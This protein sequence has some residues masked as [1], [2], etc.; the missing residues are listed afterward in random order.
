MRHTFLRLAAAAVTLLSLAGAPAAH[1]A[2]L[3]DSGTSELTSVDIPVPVSHLPTWVQINASTAPIYAGDTGTTTVATKVPR[4]TFLK[5]LAAGSVRLQ[6]TLY[7]AN[8]QPGPTGWVEPDDVAPSAPATDWLVAARSTTLQHADGSTRQLDQ[9]APLQQTDGPVQ[10]RLEVRVYK[11]DFSGVL[12][13]GWVSASDTGPALPPQTHVPSGDATLGRRAAAAPDAQQTFL[14][15]AEGA[16]VA[17]KSQTGVPA[18]VTVAQAILESDWGR[19]TLAT[20]A[21]NYFGIKAMGGLGNDGVVWL[22]TSEFNADGQEYQT[23]SPFRAYKSLT[24]SLVDHDRL[25]SGLARYAPAMQAASDPRQFA[26]LLSQAGYSTDPSYADK[27]IALMDSYNL[28]GL[29]A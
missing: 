12:D 2:V 5:V 14:K 6:I 24:D 1:A 16:A 28:Y 22:P 7:D 8:A 9:F 18:S 29:D 17:A 21:S 25:L 23:I 15:Q 4:F 13:Q 20:G 3:F 19:S 26:Q 10:G 11:P 27:L